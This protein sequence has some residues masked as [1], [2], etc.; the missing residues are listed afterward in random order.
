[1]T[2]PTK[3]S[4]E[5]DVAEHRISVLLDQGVYRHLRFGR[6]GSSTYRFH[7]VTYP[8]SLVI[9]GDMGCFV[10]SRLHDMFDFFTEEEPNLGYWAEKV[11]AE[12]K[13]AGVEEFSFEKFKTCVCED[14]ESFLEESEWSDAAKVAL[15]KDMSEE[16]TWREVNSH[17]CFDWAH[18]YAFDTEGGTFSFQDFFE[19]NCDEYSYQFVWCCW[20]II[21]AIREYRRFKLGVE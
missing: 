3:E 20:A 15:R 5:K 18:N 11:E 13:G 19:H 4:F 14:V 16:L 6:P 1:M 21:Y 9:S 7:I 8:G 17:S 2:E 12:N 10:F